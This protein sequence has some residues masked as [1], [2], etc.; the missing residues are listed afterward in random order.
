MRMS[1][2]LAMRY[3]G[4]TP[5]FLALCHICFKSVPIPIPM[6]PK[7][8]HHVFIVLTALSI[9]S[10][11]AV[12]RI[13]GIAAERMV[14]QMTKPRT[15]FG[16]FSHRKIQLNSFFFCV[17]AFS[18]SPPASPFPERN[19]QMNAM[20]V[21][22]IPSAELST[23]L[24]M[25]ATS[26]APSLTMAADAT[27][28]PVWSILPPIHAPAT[29]SLIPVPRATYAWAYVRTTV[30]NTTREMHREMSSLGESRTD[31]TA[32]MAEAPHHV[33]P[34]HIRRDSRASTFRRRVPARYPR[35]RAR[36]DPTHATTMAGRPTR[37]M[38]PNSTASDASEHLMKNSPSL[39][40]SL[41]LGSRPMK[42]E[43]PMP[44]PIRID[45]VA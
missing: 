10:A 33:A 1:S 39:A 44:M 6:N 15:N 11:S 35:I 38:M 23:I 42:G 8:N 37:A 19:C 22:R 2:E 9:A 36:G 7:A 34:V 40:T 26:I 32:L 43:L 25:A 3:T 24:T 29:A 14:E 17:G 5:L 13:E 31:P 45:R 4:M 12:S 30:A 27:T 16:N 28:L 20:T 41:A 21:A 18:P